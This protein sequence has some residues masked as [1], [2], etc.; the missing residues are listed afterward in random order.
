MLCEA[1]Q[2]ISSGWDGVPPY[3]RYAKSLKEEE[4]GA[5]LPW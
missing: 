1:F 3:I 2:L 5:A 4:R